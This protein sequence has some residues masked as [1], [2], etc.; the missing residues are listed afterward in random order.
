MFR[1][2]HPHA[3][4][5][6]AHVIL[7]SRDSNHYFAIYESP[8]WS[9]RRVPRLSRP[10]ATGAGL[11]TPLPLPR[12]VQPNIL[13]PC[14]GC[15]HAVVSVRMSAAWCPALRCPTC[16]GL[17]NWTVHRSLHRQIHPFHLPGAISTSRTSAGGTLSSPWQSVLFV[18][19]LAARL[20]KPAFVTPT[21]AMCHVPVTKKGPI[22]A[23]AHSQLKGLT[24]V[25][26]RIGFGSGASGI[27]Y[28][29][30]TNII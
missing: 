23:A 5:F 25:F 2:R 7:V 27:S 29:H 9:G 12:V 19:F 1:H 15:N 20:V 4:L 14:M 24:R 10:A 16:F 22:N 13:F 30:M 6:A 21:I 3:C 28:N 11:G 8:K 18:C 17:L 26:L